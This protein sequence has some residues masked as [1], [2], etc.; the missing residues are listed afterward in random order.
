M[1]IHVLTLR[2]FYYSKGLS[3]AIQCFYLFRWISQTKV[4]VLCRTHPT[5]A[6]FHPFRQHWRH[7]QH[8]WRHHKTSTYQYAVK[9]VNAV[10]I[11]WYNTVRFKT[12]T[13]SRC[14]LEPESHKW[15]LQD[16][17][18]RRRSRYFH[19]FPFVMTFLANFVVYRFYRYRY[20]QP[21]VEPYALCRTIKIQLSDQRVSK[22]TCALKDWIWKFPSPA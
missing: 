15:S 14:V 22:K 10:R 2:H 20:R 7:V 11:A 9:T 1:Y 18:E 4:K 16:M 13:W 8:R 12:A 17:I 21:F 6:V 5:S 3:V 19:P